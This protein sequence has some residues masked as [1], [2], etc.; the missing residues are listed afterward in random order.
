MRKTL[1]IAALMLAFCCPALAGE[2][3]NPP[4][5]Q[6]RGM[7]VEQPNTTGEDV[8]GATESLT[9]VALDVLLS[10]LSLL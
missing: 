9:Q 5:P 4:A 1:A 3:P 10:A 7:T 8:T 2:I 6:P